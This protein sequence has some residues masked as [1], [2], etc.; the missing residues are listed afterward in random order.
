MQKKI[1][2]LIVDDSAMVRKILTQAIA[3]DP[4]L[5]VVGSAPEAFVARD[6][7][8]L[9]QPDVL[10][11]DIEMPRMDGLTFL[12]KLMAYHPMPVI[13]LSSLAKEGCEVAMK[14]LELGAFE[15]MAKPGSSY[16]VQDLS[17]QLIEKIKA[18]ARL[19]HCIRPSPRAAAIPA[20]KPSSRRLFKSSG[21]IIA[22]GASTGGTDAI[23]YVLASLPAEMPPI[24]VVQHMPQHFTRAFAERLDGL[25]RLEVKEA[26]D[27]DPAEPGVVLLAPGNKHMALKRRGSRYTVEIKDGPLVCHQRPSVDVLFRSVAACAG[28]DGIGVILTGMGQDGA[29]GLLAMKEAGALTLGQDEESCVVYGM[30]KEAAEIGAVTKVL[31]LAEIPQA[32]VDACVIPASPPPP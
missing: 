11:L 7:I 28:A 25:C 29:Q 8:V 12:E 3:A 30:P 15:V 1:K 22:I 17:E 6:K 9:L 24:L 4:A 21:R 2:V 23:K 31:P 18:V 32:L 16:T 27:G 14:A 5:E 26:A 13:I 20:I 10:I 19:R